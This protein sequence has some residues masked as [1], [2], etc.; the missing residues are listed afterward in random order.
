MPFW[1]IFVAPECLGIM[2]RLWRMSPLVHI[3][4]GAIIAVFLLSPFNFEQDLTLASV[5]EQCA[6][7]LN[8][9]CLSGI[10]Y[11]RMSHTFPVDALR[12]A[13]SHFRD[14]QHSFLLCLPY[15]L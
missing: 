9:V 15:S 1:V 7:H 2:T 13:F 12:N 14:D 3:F 11:H 6:F 8:F 5:R 10:I 4:L